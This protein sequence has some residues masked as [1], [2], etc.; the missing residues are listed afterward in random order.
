MVH[1]RSYRLSTEFKTTL[2]S[3]GPSGALSLKSSG[4]SSADLL[5]CLD[6]CWLLRMHWRLLLML[7]RASLA[8]VR[9]SKMLPL[10]PIRARAMHPQSAR[11]PCVSG[12]SAS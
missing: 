12:R 3:S 11:R 2:A 9:C 10:F 1:V 6:R 4:G 7:A 8:S 5:L